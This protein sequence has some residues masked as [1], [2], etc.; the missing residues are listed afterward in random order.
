[1][2]WLLRLLSGGIN[3]VQGIFDLGEFMGRYTGV[4]LYGVFTVSFTLEHFQVARGEMV[5][6]VSHNLDSVY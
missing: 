1:M 4:D 5:C 2:W 3:V 6:F